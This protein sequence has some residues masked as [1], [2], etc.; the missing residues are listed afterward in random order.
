MRLLELPPEIRKLILRLLLLSSTPIGQSPH[1]CH[2]QHKHEESITH[3]IPCLSA[4]VLLACRQLFREGREILYN[5]NTASIHVTLKNRVGL[6]VAVL[7]SVLYLFADPNSGKG[8]NG[9]ENLRD[10]ELSN[11][12]GRFAN[13]SISFCL[14]P[15]VMRD[16]HYT[17]HLSV[18]C[19][20]LSGIPDFA[21]KRV[22]IGIDDDLYRRLH[23]PLETMKMLRSRRI[24]VKGVP[25][26]TQRRWRQNFVDETPSIPIHKL[27]VGLREFL[28]GA[29][30]HLLERQE[31]SD[32]RKR[33][34]DHMARSDVDALR[35]LVLEAIRLVEARFL[36]NVRG[37][38]V[39]ARAQ[40]TLPGPPSS[41]MNDS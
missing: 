5:D 28:F 6:Q 12:A 19:E 34:N 31:S 22:E 4:Q 18:F 23:S 24:T 3:T 15:D 38:R 25:E 14:D 27:F 39:I 36:E 26:C 21:Q 33:S 41:S 35:E 1:D 17:E 7:G 10:E 37:L 2:S 13:L 16:E 20:W 32:I 29:A 8:K 11:F 40:N 9:R 30:Q